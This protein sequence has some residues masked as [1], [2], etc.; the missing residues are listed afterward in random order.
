MTARRPSIAASL[1]GAATLAF[2]A[3][4]SVPCV[5]RANALLGVELAWTDGY[6]EV[7]LR[8]KRRL[9]APEMSVDDG[10]LRLS[11]DRID[12]P[13]SMKREGDG[14]AIEA[15]TASS[16]GAGRATIDLRFVKKLRIEAST[17]LISRGRQQTRIRI[18]L[19]WLAAHAPETKA[20]ETAVAVDTTQAQAPAAVAT[21]AKATQSRSFASGAAPARSPRGS[22][23]KFAR[24]RARGG[25]PSGVGFGVGSN[26]AQLR[27]G[28][29]LILGLG[30]LY[31][32]IQLRKKKGPTALS[33][34]EV[35]CQRRLAPKHHLVIVRA[36]GEDHLLS[37]H[38]NDTK[39]L[40]SRPAPGASASPTSV[41]LSG[42]GGKIPGAASNDGA[43]IGFVDRLRSKLR[44][45][46]PRLD[47]VE[48]VGV[49]H[50]GGFAAFRA[51]MKRFETPSLS[52]ASRGDSR[53]LE[54]VQGLLRLRQQGQS[55]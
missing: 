12:R 22:G 40:V 43:E 3:L 49:V 31:V 8:S 17:V 25:K 51:E 55:G 16:D 44:Y 32:W 24:S 23:G 13:F 27:W 46:L 34:I 30:L 14:V 19:A 21:A 45:P 39:H 50:H 5:A 15:I 41:D 33:P 4:C 47:D 38:G 18:P 10:S 36:L 42:G 54:S 48:P 1:A 9:V 37:V 29:V 7:L 2:L 28:M 52:E 26:S 53:H 6:A 11:F 20:A 35:V